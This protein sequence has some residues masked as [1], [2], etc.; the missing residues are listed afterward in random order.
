MT[1]FVLLWYILLQY[2]HHSKD[3]ENQLELSE[4]MKV[5]QWDPSTGTEIYVVT[6]SD[7]FCLERRHE[8]NDDRI[9]YSW[10]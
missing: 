5:G 4:V 8:F 10:L 6:F 2:C 1:I 7:M 9:L 3:S